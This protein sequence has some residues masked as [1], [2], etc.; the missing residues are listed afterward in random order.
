M[1]DNYYSL[2]SDRLF[3][4]TRK[5]MKRYFE[6]IHEGDEIYI[7]EKFDIMDK[8][9]NTRGDLMRLVTMLHPVSRKHFAKLIPSD[10]AYQIALYYNSIP[11]ENYFDI[12]K[13]HGE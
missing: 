6:V 4:E 9:T 7:K 12:T 3:N 8:M 13:L 11:G 2:V 10:I 1:L 5:Y